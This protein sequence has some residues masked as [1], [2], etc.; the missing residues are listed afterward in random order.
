M[1]SRAPMRNAGSAA[2]GSKFL[3]VPLLYKIF[4]ANL[5]F[6][7]MVIGAC[8]A[9]VLAAPAHTA[10]TALAESFVW[11]A[12]LAAAVVVPLQLSLVRLALAPVT[13]LEETAGRVE[14]GDFDARASLSPLA[15]PRIA[16]LTVVFNRLLE[17]VA[18]DRQRLRGV[19]AH[20]FR[21]QEGERVRIAHE[22][23]EESAQRLAG[24]LFRLR[25]TRRA[26]DPE[27]RE[28][29][30]ELLR[31]DITE[32]LASLRLY[33]SHLRPPA[34]HELG[35]LSALRSY[36]RTLAESDARRVVVRGDEV[37]DALDADVQVALYR[38]VQDAVSNSFHH[39]GADLVDVA[40]AR[41]EREVSVAIEDRGCGFDV[42]A[43]EASE[44]C[45]G[46]HGMRE[47]IGY[48]GGTLEIESR[49]GRGTL[50]RARVPIA[51]TGGCRMVEA[52]EDRLLVAAGMA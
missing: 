5:A 26:T 24:V 29:Q 50:V 11:V 46:I 35:L 22:L 51:D 47:R 39:S 27:S 43:T 19:A 3:R 8:A 10:P 23:E 41:T 31:A 42:A 15:D 7:L 21:A 14:D 40:V 12:L 37:G 30:F 16:R 45:L 20:A 48:V 17:A 44:S 32:V 13:R 1:P 4:G 6:V 28:A 52:G 18:R 25:A 38:I 2:Q 9:F 36:G 33:A 34:V 49:P